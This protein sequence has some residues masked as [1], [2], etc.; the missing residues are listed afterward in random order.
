MRVCICLRGVIVGNHISCQEKQILRRMS[1]NKKI[2]FVN[3]E[4]ATNFKAVKLG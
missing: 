1:E 4:V 2:K 3:M